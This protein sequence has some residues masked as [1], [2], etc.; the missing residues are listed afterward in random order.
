M[1]FWRGGLVS[2]GAFEEYLRDAFDC[3]HAESKTACRIMSIGIHC[4]IVGTPARSRALARFL[5]YA[6]SFKDVWFSRRIDIA[7]C[8]LKQGP[9]LTF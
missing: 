2:V 1:R 9:P 3:L 6:R 5:E 8:W 4:R 7:R